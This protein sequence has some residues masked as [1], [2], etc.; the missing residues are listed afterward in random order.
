MKRAC[1]IN[2][3]GKVV[4]LEINNMNLFPLQ[5]AISVI[6][7]KKMVIFGDSIVELANCDPKNGL[8]CF[9]TRGKYSELTI[10]FMNRQFTPS[11]TTVGAIGIFTAECGKCGKCSLAILIMWQNGPVV[12]NI[13]ITTRHGN[14]L[15][16]L[17]KFTQR[18]EEM[19]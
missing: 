3:P 17:D 5:A 7:R 9:L 2:E 13:Y 11:C 6:N 14:F 10:H 8:D 4:N 1:V 18:V 16:P 12:V 15:Q 19:A